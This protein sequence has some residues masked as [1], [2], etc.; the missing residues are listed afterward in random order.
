INED[1]GTSASPDIGTVVLDGVVVTGAFGKNAFAVFNYGSIDGFSTAGDGVDL[2]DA[3]TGWGPVLNIDGIVADYDAGALDIEL[4]ATGTPTELQGDKANQL[5][6]PEDR[7][8]EIGGTDADDRM[9]GKGGSDTIHGGNGDDEIYGHDKPGEAQT[10]DGGDD[11]LFGD[12]GADSLY[13]GNGADRLDG[14]TG[15]DRLDGGGGIDT[16]AYGAGA[17]I[18]FE[19]GK[20]VVHAGLDAD[21]LAGTEK[22]EIDGATYLLVDTLAGAGG[23]ATLADAVAA[24]AGGDTI[25]MAPGDHTGNVTVDKSVTI[26]GLDGAVLEGTFHEL[27]SIPGDTTVADW[28]ETATAYSQTPGAGLTIAADGVTVRNLTIDDY[29]HGIALGSNDSL[30]LDDVTLSNNV[31]GIHRG[32]T[33]LV[34]SFTMTGGTIRDGALGINV[35]A[36][37]LA[38]SFDDVLI[39]GT[40]FENLTY[41]GIYIEQMNDGTIR[42]VVMDDVGEFGRPPTM[43]VPPGK[44][45]VAIDINLKYG[46]YQNITVEGFDLTNVGHSDGGGS[47]DSLGGAIVVRARDDA[48][49]YN[50]NPATLDGLTI[51]DGS[52]DGTSTG[53]RIGE[54]G[55]TNL[56]PLNAEVENVTVTGAEDGAY[57]NRSQAV[58]TVDGTAGAD[59]MSSNAAATGRFDMAGGN[60]ADTMAGGP[61]ADTLDGG[62]GSDRLDGKGGIDT[63]IYGSGAT[64]EHTGSGWVVHDGAD[65][66]TLVD[67]EKVAIDGATYLLVDTAGDGFANLADAVAAAANGETI[68]M[69]PGTYATAAQVLIDKTVTIEGAGA[70]VVLDGTFNE[71]NASFAGATADWLKTATSIV[72]T[73]TG[74][75]LAADSITLRDLTIRDFAEGISLADGDGIRLEDILLEDNLTAM[76]KGTAAQIHD[77]AMTG[78]AIQDGGLGIAIFGAETVGAFSGVVIGGVQLDDL[79]YKGLYFEQLDH[80]T[81]GSVVMDHVGDFGRGAA[82]TYFGAGLGS[83]GAGIDVNLKY[84]AYSDILIENFTFTEVGTSDGGGSPH[85]GGGAILLKARDD[86][87][88]YD[89]YPATL[90]GVTV[91]NGSID[92]TSVGIRIGE[93]GK[94]NAGPT[95]TVVTDV[96]ITGAVSGAYD[97][98]TLSTLHVL[99]TNQS[100]GM[101]SHDSAT[102][103]F[104]MTAGNAPDTIEGA[105]GNDTLA[106]DAG[107]DLLYGGTGADALSGG[108]GKDRIYAGADADSIV[109]GTEADSV[110]GLTTGD[111]DQDTVFDFFRGNK[112]EQSDAIV[113]NGNFSS[114]NN[115]TLSGGELDFGDG[116]SMFLRLGGKALEGTLLAEYS[117]GSQRTVISV[118]D[119]GGGPTNGPDILNG[120][121]K[122]NSIDGLNGDDVLYGFAGNDT[123]RGSNGQ[124]LVYGGADADLAY[125]GNGNDTIHGEDGNDRVVGDAGND[126]GYGGNGNDRLEGGS[127]TDTM[128][129]GNGDDTIYG[130]DAADSLFGGPGG[131]RIYG[132]A[133]GDWI[134]LGA[135]S[136]GDGTRDT[137]YG[138]VAHLSGDTILGFR[139]GG[140]GVAEADVIAVT[141]LSSSNGKYLDSLVL[142]GNVLSLSKVGG[143]TITFEDL[144][145]GTHFTDTVLGAT[146]EILLYVL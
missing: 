8:Q 2:S 48:S 113:V 91:D 141:G 38:G 54:P 19:G 30:T 59:L 89:T 23:F 85:A 5:A 81:I 37:V 57:D 87:P 66:D 51:R 128:D 124:D 76:R 60:G 34:T 102:G 139:T 17:T 99:G 42:D 33:A 130:G 95:S 46:D 14:G 29:V 39:D 9:M 11:H 6:D 134:V 109:G 21:T 28:L 45:G 92:G 52:I 84:G 13:G 117:A 127:G 44:S 98:R 32:P 125:G 120:D 112:T 83:F 53:V 115:A 144:S 90:T 129:G 140:K 77:F 58:L 4:P 78:G 114:L 94:T 137:V 47:N 67:V 10:V 93:P 7:D 56:G 75:V 105:A 118:L 68:L 20:W 27:H 119:P 86:T 97:N 73:G 43:G 103:A 145:A 123:L 88:S 110:F 18:A 131:D 63:A 116:N 40:T 25:V 49:S 121:G 136:A 108:A 72:Q 26:E 35:E 100:D 22:V 135:D 80:A 65:T 55:K 31:I 69:A 3:V 107:D 16:A 41:K 79:I 62:P 50:T 82:D 133:I 15:S 146:G 71:A 1:L 61:A 101:T 122:G 24:A 36:G 143:G 74:L 132:E 126:L 106:G 96:T 142:S 111:L 12:A 64:V 104:D 70:G 138:T